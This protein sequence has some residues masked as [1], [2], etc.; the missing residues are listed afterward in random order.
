MRLSNAARRDCTVGEIVNL[1][2][3]DAQRLQDSPVFLQMAWAGPVTIC[4]AIYFVW[5]QLG[6]ASLAGFGVVLLVLPLNFMLSK[7]IRSLQV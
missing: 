1:M 5:Q 3:V 7:A 2:S 6:A 4:I